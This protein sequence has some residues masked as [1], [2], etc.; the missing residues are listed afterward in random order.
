MKPVAIDRKSLHYRLATVYSFGEI[1]AGDICSYTKKV[2]WGILSVGAIIGGG[3]FVAIFVGHTVAWITACISVGSWLTADELALAIPAM[4]A[5]IAVL[6][7]GYFAYDKIADH[8]DDDQDSFIKAAYISWK[9]K[10]C[11]PIEFK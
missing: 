5:I 2:L 11:V 6:C 7:G 1:G 3:G 10:F 9:D 4:A 8:I